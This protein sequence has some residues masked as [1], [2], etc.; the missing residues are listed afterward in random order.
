MKLCSILN[1]EPR[2]FREIAKN[3]HDT[4]GFV[5]RAGRYYYVTPEIVARVGFDLAWNNWIKEDPTEFLTKVPKI[6]LEPFYTRVKKSASEEV[7]GIIGEFFRRWRTGLRPEQLN[8]VETID[9]LITLIEVEPGT[10]L[11]VLRSLIEQTTMDDLKNVSGDNIQGSYG[12]RRSIVWLAERIVAFPE[13]FDDAEN[14][15]L[16]LGLAESEKNIV[17]NA[18]AIWRQLYRIFLSGAAVPFLDR[19]KRLK[20]RILSDDENVSRFAAGAFEGILNDYATRM[21]GPSIVAG[22]IPP[23]EYN[24]N[25]NIEYFECISATIALLRELINRDD[26][27]GSIK[28]IAESTLV[29][30]TRTLLNHGFSDELQNTLPEKSLDGNLRTKLIGNIEEFLYF[31]IKAKWGRPALSDDYVEKVNEW[32]KSLKPSKLKGRISILVGTLRGHY[33]LL[34]NEN[35][36]ESEIKSLAK[37]CLQFPENLKQEKEILFSPDAKNAIDFGYGLGNLDE[38]AI[39]LNFVI[40]SSI[41]YNSTE[42]GR[43]YI[44]GL[45][46]SHPQYAGLINRKLDEIQV[47]Y[48]AVAYE[49]FM[50]RIEITKAFVRTLELVDSEKLNASYLCRFGYWK[51]EYQLTPDN[52]EKSLQRLVDAANKGDSLALQAAL[53]FVSRRIFR[54]KKGKIGQIFDVIGIRS[55][56]W[57][58]IE[59]TPEK[60][61]SYQ[62]IQTLEAL[63]KYDLPR[64]I[65]LMALGLVEGYLHNIGEFDAFLVSLAKSNPDLLMKS[66]GEVMLDK[67]LGWKFQILKHKLL[68]KSLPEETVIEWVKEQGVE[69]ARLLARHLPLPYVSKEGLPIVPYLTQFVLDT[70]EDDEEV[71]D[72]FLYG[73]HAFQGYSGDIAA[74]HDKE[75]EIAR[76]FSRH[77]SKRIRAWAQIE[78]D[79]ARSEAERLRQYT[80]ERRLD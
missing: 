22:R 63:S 47:D 17:N 50:T 59:I 68:F 14:I 40:E 78:E 72:A 13:H 74:Q 43:G 21:A 32:L 62:W 48:P 37:E 5:A 31:D 49:L 79:H 12:P 73:V 77:P 55:L 64:A 42:F 27:S 75:A 26:I 39:F 11:P 3:L 25:D 20:E 10:Y 66:V 69:A 16:R 24:P 61:K 4:S 51:G 57:R 6:L 15:L 76:K 33:S 46:G 35:K 44:S 80:E 58:L 60:D 67:N 54:E 29:D 71:F 56:A 36:L 41:R 8:S 30:E 9:R 23:E 1:L 7:R 53:E 38:K 19:L 52:F 34:D 70:F 28:H 18:T 65:K 45:L 2:S